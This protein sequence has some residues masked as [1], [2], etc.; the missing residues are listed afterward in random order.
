M[1][2]FVG[3]QESGYYVPELTGDEVRYTDSVYHVSELQDSILHQQYQRIIIDIKNFTDSAD[4]VAAALSRL[5][6]A[7]TTRFIFFALGHSAKTTIVSALMQEGFVYFVFGPTINKAKEQLRACLNGYAT[8]EPIEEEN[9][10]KKETAKPISDSGIKS[11][12]VAGCCHRIGTTTQAIQICKY[13]LS[14]G[15]NPCYITVCEDKAAAWRAPLGLEVTKD[16]EAYS[17]T[18]IFNVDMYDDP[19]MIA[20]I[21]SLGYDYLVYDF[22]SI[23][24]ENF[25]TSQY[26]EKDI[27]IIVSGVKPGEIDGM[28]KVY[29]SLLSD[30]TY[31]IFSFVSDDTKDSILE[32]QGKLAEKT[33]FAIY[34]PDPFVFINKSI[35]IY[36][37]I[38]NIEGT[39]KQ[40]KRG[41]FGR[42]KR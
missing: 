25:S 36:Q 29:D 19:N 4:E 39:P 30:S 32:L 22:G 2:L 40:K 13:L 28:R 11:I 20:K 12:A 26:L 16:D 23:G 18:R 37:D 21:K 1:I 15:K 38:I 7:V 35:N 9:V 27:R 5:Q 8:V 31:Y 41:F 14:K 10:E 24:D 33:K 42:K 17:R 3:T 34:A 6:K